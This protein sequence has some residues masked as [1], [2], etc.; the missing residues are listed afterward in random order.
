M[1]SVAVFWRWHYVDSFGEVLLGGSNSLKRWKDPPNYQQNNSVFPF[2]SMGHEDSKRLLC[3]Q[4]I[5]KPLWRFAEE[6]RL[7]WSTCNSGAEGQLPESRTLC[8][9]LNE[10]PS[11]RNGLRHLFKRTVVP[12][13]LASPVKRLWAQRQSCTKTKRLLIHEFFLTWAFRWFKNNHLTAELKH[14]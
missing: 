12:F 7:I 9:H 13:V 10:G 5:W 4:W 3:R 2:S 14:K 11:L 8:E 1:D 6:Y